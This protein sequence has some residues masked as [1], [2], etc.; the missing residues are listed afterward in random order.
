MSDHVAQSKR[1]LN[2][3]ESR[4]YKIALLPK[5]LSINILVVR[6]FYF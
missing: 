5:M 4:L 2:I 3:Q 1:V 6:F